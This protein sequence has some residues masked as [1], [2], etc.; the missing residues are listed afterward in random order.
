MLL[1]PANKT[2]LLLLRVVENRLGVQSLAGLHFLS[3]PVHH[4]MHSTVVRRL[5]AK[6][7]DSFPLNPTGYLYPHSL[8]Q[9]QL[10]SVVFRDDLD[11]EEMFCHSG[12]PV[13]LASATTG[14]SLQLLPEASPA[15]V[16]QL[17]RR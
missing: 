3:C 5:L 10:E 12:H 7:S 15:G 9:F 1:L 8:F 2:W 17:R 11:D 14:R 6:D 16:L 4:F 13:S